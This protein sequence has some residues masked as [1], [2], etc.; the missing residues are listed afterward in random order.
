MALRTT[1]D[2]RRALDRGEIV[3]YYQPIVQLDNGR[4]VGFEVLARW[5][6]PERGLLAPEQ[7]LPLAEE[8]GLIG[9]VG[10]SVLRSA[11]AKLGQWRASTAQKRGEWSITSRW[12][13]SCQTT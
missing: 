12:Q 9:D 7:F 5:R 11:V 3:P 2:L 4:T 1:D 10:A 13:T 8:T 6:H